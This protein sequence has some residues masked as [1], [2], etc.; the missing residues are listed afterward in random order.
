MPLFHIH[1]LIG[2]LLAS[3]TAGAAWSARRGSTSAE[4]WGWI[5]QF[6]PTW[7][8]AVPTMHQAIVANGADQHPAATRSPAP[9]RFVRSSSSA[10]PI[11]VM[12]QLEVVFK[13]PVLEAYGMT[14]ASHQMADQPAAAARAQARLGRQALRRRDGDPRTT[15]GANCHRRRDRRDRDSRPQRDPGY[16]NTPGANAGA[17][18]GD[19]LRTG[20]QGKLDADGYLFIT[21]RLKEMVNRGGQK[22]SPRE[23]DEVLLEHPDVAQAAVFALP[24]ASLGEDLVA[25]VVVKSARDPPTT[26]ICAS[27]CARKSLADYKVPHPVVFRRRHSQG[28]DRQDPAHQPAR[29]TRPCAGP[30]VRRPAHRHREDWSRRSFARS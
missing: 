5:A 10:L 4:F 8:T 22:I 26:P 1:G 9:L 13:A 15:P 24:H 16:E 12:G 21:G 14:E 25:A 28:R 6:E 7:Y 3:V 30:A 18:T 20:D 19:W 27:S 29:E 17:F 2:A 11:P 23:V